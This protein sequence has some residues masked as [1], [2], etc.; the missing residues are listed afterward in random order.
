MSIYEKGLMAPTV[1][2]SGH[3]GNV[4]VSKFSQCGNYLASAGR[5]RLVL[6]WD[7]FDPQCRNLGVCKGHKNAILDLIWDSEIEDQFGTKQPPRIHSCSADKTLITWDTTDFSRVRSYKGHT[8]I[9]NS[10][11]CSHKASG[12]AGTQ[13]LLVSGSDDGTVKLWDVRDTKYAKSFNL[14]YQVMSVA[15]SKLNDIIYLGGLDNTIRALNL[16]SNT[17]EYTLMGHT[18]TVT[19]LAL[20]N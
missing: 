8:D 14:G 2:L 5:D 3:Q 13:D 11:D 17:I 19:G 18:D 4:F 15:F 10:I 20:S 16:R 1:K 12:F 9:V 7:I 6:I